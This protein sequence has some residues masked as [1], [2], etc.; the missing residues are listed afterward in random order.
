[1][2]DYLAIYAVKTR[3]SIADIFNEIDIDDSGSL[4]KREVMNMFT[5]KIKVPIDEEEF[6]V[7]F[8]FVDNDRSGNIS[9]K[10]FIQVMSPAINQKRHESNAQHRN[11]N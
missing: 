11:S 5:K 9:I 2:V 10:E 1:M 7:F 6:E 4:S 3:K 8:N